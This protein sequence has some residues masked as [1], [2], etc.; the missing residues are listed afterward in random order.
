VIPLSQVDDNDNIRR[1]YLEAT[2]YYELKYKTEVEYPNLLGMYRKIL[3]IKLISIL[4]NIQTIKYCKD[5]EMLKDKRFNRT[6]AEYD[7]ARRKYDNDPKRM[8]F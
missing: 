3:M 6:F 2:L 4:I 7:Q 5:I 8:G 1:Y